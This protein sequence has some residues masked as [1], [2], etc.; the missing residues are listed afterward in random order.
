MSKTIPSSPTLFPHDREAEIAVLGSILHDNTILEWL[1]GA[2][3]P[4]HFFSVGNREI[5]Q[6]MRELLTRRTPIDEI[7]L[8]N[9]L[10]AKGKLEAAGGIVFIAELI[11]LTPVASN[12]RYYAE[13]VWEQSRKRALIEAGLD[14]RQNAES[15]DADAMIVDFHALLESVSK[16][17]LI[18]E[19]A[20]AKSILVQTFASLEGERGVVQYIPLQFELDRYAFGAPRGYPVVIA[21]RPG[22]GKTTLAWQVLF[23]NA[24]TASPAP[25]LCISLEMKHQEL[26]A[27]A[28]SNLTEV[29][30]HKLLKNPAEL[31]ALD[32]DKLSATAGRLA[33][34]PLFMIGDGRGM[35]IDQLESYVRRY[36][37][38]RGAELVMIDHLKLIK[39]PRAR[40]GQEAQSERITRIKSLA[41][42]TNTAIIVV[43]QINRAGAERPRM[44]HLEWSSDIEKEAYWIALLHTEEREDKAVQTR[45]ILDKNRS[46]EL[47]QFAV[48]W[49]PHIYRMGARWADQQTLAV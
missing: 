45:V 15:R 44:E 9:H 49:A 36:V 27:R 34:A 2:L 19:A 43:A 37:A 31:T 3:Q 6:A 48:E 21:A 35:T 1:G 30:G 24:M 46:G 22:V 13:I 38:E 10:R 5:Y 4:E 33:E 41:A 17:K 28:L 42:E 8:A 26:M 25:A 40:D 23:R 32:W 14:A 47:V 12:A 29:S 16:S 7:T 20:D 39:V 11:D 18:E